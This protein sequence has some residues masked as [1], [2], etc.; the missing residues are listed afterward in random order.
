MTTTTRLTLTNPCGHINLTILFLIIYLRKHGI[1]IIIV[2]R[3]SNHASPK[4]R[5]VTTI[6]FVTFSHHC[7]YIM[8]NV[9]VNHWS[10]LVHRRLTCFL[11]IHTSYLLNSRPALHRTSAEVV[12]G[13]NRLPKAKHMSKEQIDGHTFLLFVRPFLLPFPFCFSYLCV[14]Y[15]KCSS[16]RFLA[17]SRSFYLCVSFA[18]LGVQ[19]R[20]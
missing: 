7:L 19:A 8:E 10:F 17:R 11:P 13:Y 1:L 9:L 5:S 14:L 4:R 18:Y 6:V 2:P 20:M 15:K 12:L 16:M 3:G